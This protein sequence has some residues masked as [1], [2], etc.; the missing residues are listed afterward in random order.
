MFTPVLTPE[1]IK[2]ILKFN[3]LLKFSPMPICPDLH[4]F[5]VEKY[6]SEYY[7]VLLRRSG[8]YTLCRGWKLNMLGAGLA[9]FTYTGQGRQNM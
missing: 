2:G 6:S 1:T 4:F 5:P 3:Y 8:E 7:R 9:G